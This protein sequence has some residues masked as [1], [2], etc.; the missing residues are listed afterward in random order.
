MDNSPL[1][2]NLGLGNWIRQLQTVGY[3]TST[4]G[5]THDYSYNG[6]YPDKR[7]M[8]GYQHELGIDVIDEIPGPRTLCKLKSYLHQ[9]IEKARLVNDYE[10]NLKEKI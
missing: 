9:E 6:A 4:F 5:K 3:E 10:S 7:N 1:I 8:E 2:V